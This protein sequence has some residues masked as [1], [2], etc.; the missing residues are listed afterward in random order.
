MGFLT[1]QGVRYLALD[2]DGTLYPKRML[3]ERMA[4]SF[5]PSPRLALAFNWA[6]SAYRRLQEEEPTHPANRAGLLERQ[7]ALV[8]SRLKTEQSRRVEAAIH[9]QFYRAWERSF[10]SIKP[11]AHLRES[12]VEARA[13]GLTIVVLS[14]FPVADK[15]KTLGIEDLVSAAFCS[16]ESGYL[17]PSGHAFALILDHL[18]CEASEI[19]YVGDS[20]SK[21]C[22][23]AKAVG[24]HTALMGQTE[25]TRYPDADLV[26]HSWKELA[27]LIL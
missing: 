23:G 16:E 13:Q 18:G 15:L 25:H 20:Y 17:K 9:R 5:F 7:A 24:M 6:R 4:R 2:I 11:F 8:A 1:D 22:V 10:R 3:N 19:L 26:V 21:D 14:D 27:A 12:L